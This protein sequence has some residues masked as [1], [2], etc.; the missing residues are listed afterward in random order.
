MSELLIKF[1]NLKSTTIQY[2]MFD[3]LKCKLSDFVAGEI[4]QID[5]SFVNEKIVTKEIS[6]KE[7]I[8]TLQSFVENNKNKFTVCGLYN[9]CMEELREIKADFKWRNSKD[10]KFIIKIEHWIESVRPKLQLH[11][12]DYKIFI[13]RSIFN[14]K[15]LVIGGILNSEGEIERVKNFIEPE[16]PPVVPTFRFE[17]DNQMMD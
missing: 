16:N 6:T 13:G 14:P 8:M 3:L 5:I 4:L 1:E 2:S 15:E 10:G 17:I 11:F 9:Y 7:D 12:R